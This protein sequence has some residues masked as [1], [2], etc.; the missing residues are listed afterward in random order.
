MDV[1]SVEPRIDTQTDRFPLLQEVMES[2]TDREHIIDIAGNND[3]S[4]SSYREDH[5][6]RARLPQHEGRLSSGTDSPTYHASSSN[7]LNSRNSS[8]MRASDGYGLRRRSPMNPGLWIS[9][10]LVF[11]VGQIIASIVVLSLSRN[12]HPQAPLFGWIVGYASGCVATVPILYWRYHNRNQTHEQDSP[13]LHQA[14]SQ[15]NPPELMSYEAVSDNQASDE[16]N[17]HTSEIATRNN[18]TT[19]SLS[20]R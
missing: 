10:E 8:F 3:D 20:T 2:H 9:V 4:P 7:R 18:G 16:E 15:I 11:T 17:N 1:P 12:E 19:G 6:P 13:H 14:S 5:S